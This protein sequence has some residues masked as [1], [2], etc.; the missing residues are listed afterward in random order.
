MHFINF[1]FFQC[2]PCATAPQ[3]VQA[4]FNSQAPQCDDEVVVTWARP[5]VGEVDLYAII[6][7]S[8]K[9]SL[10]TTVGGD[11]NAAVL[12]PLETPLVEYTCSVFAVNN[13]GISPPGVSNSILTL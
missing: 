12:G 6:C 1:I 2:R 3:R 10:N 11:R 4:E 8:E 13:A 9:G 7:S 5:L